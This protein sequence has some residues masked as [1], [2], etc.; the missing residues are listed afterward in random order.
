M[1]SHVTDSVLNGARFASAEMVSIFSDENRISKWLDIE[2]AMAQTQAEL[3]LIPKAAADEI[4]DKANIDLFDLKDLGEGIK[5]VG[6]NMVPFV[7]MFAG[8]C[9]GDA[10]QYVHYGATTQ[11][12]VDTA[13]MLQSKDALDLVRRDLAAIRTA[14]AEKAKAFKTTPMAGRT[15]G[16][17]ALPISFGYKLATWVDEIDRHFDRLDEGAPR[18][19]V[20]NLTGAVGT[21]ASFDGK[22]IEVQQGT[23]ERL[24]LGVPRICWHSSRDRVVE[25][26]FLIFQVSATLSKIANEVI[27]LSKTEFGEVAEPFR[28]GKVGSST[29]PHKRNPS[30]CELVTALGYLVRGGIVPLTDA[31]FQE[32]ERDSRCWRIEWA[33]LPEMFMYAG[34]IL[35]QMRVVAEGLVVNEDRMRENLDMTGGLIL[36]ERVM[37][38]LG[39]KIGKQN[40][41]ALVYDIAMKAHELGVPFSELLSNNEV[42]T[43]N[44]DAS[45]IA[46]LLDP[47]SYLG[48][49]SQVVEGVVG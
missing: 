22:G 47:G 41:H 8:I 11:D 23:M 42:V 43:Q 2:A 12:V 15:H 36:S 49:T 31:L 19:L 4:S 25:L 27:N 3:G 7:R 16:Q 21:M 29:M 14:L 5:A 39:E 37:F 30:T 33:A 35:Q 46:D 1:G 38:T 13:L 20:G 32:H 40:A 6:H 28:K 18:I 45:L 48:E 26:A 34:A 17:Q 24:G 9:D 44:M 10:G